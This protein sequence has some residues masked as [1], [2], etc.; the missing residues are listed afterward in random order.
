MA[1]YNVVTNIDK[2]SKEDREEG[3]KVRQSLSAAVNYGPDVEEAICPSRHPAADVA[4]SLTCDDE[5]L[6]AEQADQELR[7]AIA[8][9]ETID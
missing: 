4:A 1:R 7:D 6:A 8:E 2:S 3:T 9:L 5:Y